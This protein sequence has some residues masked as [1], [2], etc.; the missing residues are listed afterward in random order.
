MK[1]KKLIASQNEGAVESYTTAAALYSKCDCTVKMAEA[2]G[3]IGKTQFLQDQYL[4]A[5]GHFQ[6]ALA[7]HSYDQE[8]MHCLIACSY[9][10]LANATQSAEDR[11]KL[12]EAA[13]FHF[14][15][16][17]SDAK[18]QNDIYSL[19][20]MAFLNVEAYVDEQ[21]AY[22]DEAIDNA[23]KTGSLYMEASLY[24][25]SALL[26][27]SKGSHS[28]AIEKLLVSERLWTK[29]RNSAIRD[30]FIV[31]MAN[32]IGPALCQE[33]LMR[34]YIEGARDSAKALQAADR[35]RG[36]ALLMEFQRRSEKSSALLDETSFLSFEQ[37]KEFVQKKKISLIFYGM[38]TDSDRNIV[39]ICL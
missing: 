33:L 18:K 26:L 22:L 15:A 35:G 13:C 8:K 10:R 20:A 38:L 17:L 9:L 14:Q 32:A 24:L 29:I 36:I 19:T 12:M 34:E 30:N 6:K 16:Q 2:L 5:I 7:V 31:T 37:I 1:Q 3:N 39:T 4:E 23:H 28:T 27:I 11:K 25:G 21:L